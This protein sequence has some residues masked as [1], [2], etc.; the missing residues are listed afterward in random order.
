MIAVVIPVIA[1]LPLQRFF[2]SGIS[3]SGLKE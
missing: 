3:G 2:V 1:I